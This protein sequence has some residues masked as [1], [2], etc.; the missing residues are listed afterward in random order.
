MTALLL[1]ALLTCSAAAAVPP[2]SFDALFAA[3]DSSSLAGRRAIV[4]GASSGI[5]K[6]TAC[7]LAAKGCDLVLISRRKDRLKEIKSEVALRCPAVS[8]EVVAGDVTDAALYEEMERRRCIERCS[9]LINNAGL[10]RGKDF[11]GGADRSAWKEMI[12]AN[13]LGAFLMVDAVLPHMVEEGGGHIISTGSIAGLEA[14]EGGSVYCATKHALHAFMKALRYETYSK[15]VRVTTVA[16]GFVGEGT[17]FS[18]VR[19]SGNL[20]LAAATYQGMQELRATD[21]A[22][23]ILWALEQPAHVNL[24]LIQIMPT[25]QGGATRIHRLPS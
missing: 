20:D 22:S 11:V 24:D 13:C 9:I 4:T 1:F 25:A 14:Y 18:E 2:Q 10:A 23:Q 15:G 5:G 7:A 17:E 8:V 19:F 21:I 16:P 12:D 3:F 6:A